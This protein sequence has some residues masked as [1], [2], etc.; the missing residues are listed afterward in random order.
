MKAL[1]RNILP[2][3]VII[4]C[5]CCSAAEE[6]VKLYYYVCLFFTVLCISSQVIMLPFAVL[7]PL[8]MWQLC[9]GLCNE[10]RVSA[11]RCTIWRRRMV[12]GRSPEWTRQPVGKKRSWYWMK[13]LMTRIMTTLSSQERDGM[14]S[15]KLTLSSA[16]GLSDRSLQ[17]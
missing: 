7:I 9:C 3:A 16:K 5:K 8:V 15:T 13:D 1:C 6:H 12:R 10:P 14:T 11:Y 4:H 2:F 17:F